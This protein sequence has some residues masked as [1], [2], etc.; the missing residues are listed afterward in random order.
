MIQS[1]LLRKTP[2][3]QS[4]LIHRVNLDFSYNIIQTTVEYEDGEEDGE[5]YSKE[6][7][8]NSISVKESSV[9]QSVLINPDSI[10]NDL[11]RKSIDDLRSI[12]F[13]THGRAGY[14]KNASFVENSSLL[15]PTY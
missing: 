11:V 14:H 6:L 10:E 8:K 13:Y 3:D 1:S 7:S 12:K 4:D 2:N 9:S 15:K 5:R